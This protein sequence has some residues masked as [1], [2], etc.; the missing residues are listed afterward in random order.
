MILK[1]FRK[2]E[3]AG[4]PD[5]KIRR[6]MTK[7]YQSNDNSM[8][9]FI[10]SDHWSASDGNFTE[11]EIYS[12][13][14]IP[15]GWSGYDSYGRYISCYGPYDDLYIYDFDINDA[16]KAF[17]INGYKKVLISKEKL[18][19]YNDYYESYNEDGKLYADIS[20]EDLEGYKFN[21]LDDEDMI[22][23]ISPNQ[24]K[25][26]AAEARFNK[27]VDLKNKLNR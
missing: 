7:N 11:Q 1:T 13:Y 27:S 5:I 21:L 22:V 2:K 12:M 19:D 14:S 4:I 17:I 6:K 26:A 10:T 24:E 8:D 23:M 9:Y 18:E 15:V 3:A 20:I 16:S 25:L